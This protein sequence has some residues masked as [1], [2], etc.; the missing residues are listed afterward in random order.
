MD[1]KKDNKKIQ[2]YMTLYM[3]LGMCFGVSCGLL[4]G[5]LLFKDNIAL[6]MCIG[7]SVG[8]CIGMAI[9]A[10]KDKRLSENMMTVSRIEIVPESPNAVIYVIDKNGVEKAYKTDEKKMKEEKFAVGDRV[11]EESDGALVSL[12]SK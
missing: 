12:E 10:A 5:M 9:G 11:A 8:M 3:S 1:N 4:Y 2:K 7:I 6:G